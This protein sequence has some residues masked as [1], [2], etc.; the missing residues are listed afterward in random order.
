LTVIVPA[1][2]LA[3]GRVDLFLHPPR[4]NFAVTTTDEE[5]AAFAAHASGWAAAGRQGADPGR[6]NLGRSTPARTWTA[7]DGSARS[8]VEVVAEELGPSLR[9]A[10]ATTTR[11][12]RNSGQ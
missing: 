10:T 9:W 6:L 5:R 1:T 12:T 4:D 11:T 2:I 7:E 8:T 3:H